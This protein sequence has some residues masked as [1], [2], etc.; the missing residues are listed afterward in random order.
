VLPN[1]FIFITLLDAFI[2]V[3]FYQQVG[4]TLSGS[5]GGSSFNFSITD[6]SYT[7]SEL[8]SEINTQFTSASI[9]CVV[10]YSKI[11][12]KFTFTA[13]SNVNIS[14]NAST[15]LPQL[16][17]DNGSQTGTTTLTSTKV[18]DLM[19]IKTLFLKINNLSVANFKDG[20]NSK[21]IASIPVT[22]ARNG[23]INYQAHSNISRKRL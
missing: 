16:G 17:F 23:I 10:S 21:I 22:S 19:P 7:A 2:P 15:Y 18:V 3:S 13:G 4:M 20:L 1:H 11:N 9:S 8:L 5:V 12:N 6:G 14:L